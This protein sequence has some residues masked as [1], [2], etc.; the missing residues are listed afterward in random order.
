[1]NLPAWARWDAARSWAEALQV[2]ADRR[3]ECL[4]AG[5]EYAAKQYIWR[6]YVHELHGNGQFW[7]ISGM[8]R[9]VGA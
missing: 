6:S 5:R 7:I 2:A 4:A 3:A 1:V 9:S 8:P